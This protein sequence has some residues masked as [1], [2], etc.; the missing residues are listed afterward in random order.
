[1]KNLLVG[2]ALLAFA[3]FGDNLV[4]NGD[5]EA[6]GFTD[7]YKENCGSDYLIGWT[8]NKAG[9]ATPKGTYISTAIAA[10]DDS[11]WAFLKNVSSISQEITLPSAGRYRLEF[12]FCGRAG[13]Y[14]KNAN[15]VVS[16]DDQVLV[17]IV[18]DGKTE[19]GSKIEH[20]VCDFEVLASGA[21]V[22][23]F[24]QTKSGDLSPAFDNIVLCLGE[25]ANSIVVSGDP[26]NIGTVSPDFGLTMLTAGEPVACQL[27]SEAI[28]PETDDKRYSYAG[29]ELSVKDAAGE[30]TATSGPES[31]FVYNQAEGDFANLVW[32]WTT[33]YK[34]LATA[35]EGGTV[36]LAEAWVDEGRTCAITA[37]P[38]AG[39]SFT[40]WT[41]DV[42]AGFE[43][44]NPISFTVEKGAS[45]AA[46]FATPV[47][48]TVK[49]DGTGDFATLAEGV[50]A[51]NTLADGQVGELVLEPGGYP[52]TATLVLA[53]PVIVRSSTGDSSDVV[54]WADRT[55]GN[56]PVFKLAVADSVLRG[57]TISNGW[58]KTAGEGGGAT[59]VAG[60]VM[61]G[62]RVVGCS[63]DQVLGAV[64]GAYVDGGTVMATLFTG[65]M[66]AGGWNLNSGPGVYITKGGVVRGCTFTGNGAAKDYGF[67]CAQMYGGSL[68]SC[69]I[70]NNMSHFGGFY[71][72]GALVEAFAGDNFV[73]RCLIADNA[74]GGDS[75][76]AV[77][78]A[79]GN[80]TLTVE[81]STVAFNHGQKGGGF[82]R[83]NGTLTVK[84]SVVWGN[85]DVMLV[86]KRT[87]ATPEDSNFRGVPLANIVHCCSTIPASGSVVADPL[88]VDAPRGDYRLAANSPAAGMGCFD[89][90]GD[91]PA[92]EADAAD[93]VR[94]EPGDD[95][96][97]AIV[98]CREGG[99]VRVAAGD[100]PLF[101][102]GLFIAK[103]IS[104]LS[105]EGP[106]K[107]I[108][109]RAGV[110]TDEDR[111][112][113]VYIE[114]PD[115]VFGGFTLKN[116]LGSD[117][118]EVCA[119]AICARDGV[120]TNCTVRDC[121]IWSS[122]QKY[123]S[124]VHIDGTA[125]A[126]R[127][128]LRDN[129]GGGDRLGALVLSG[130]SPVVE[131]SIVSNQT[132]GTVW[133]S[134]AVRL[135]A[136][137]A[138]LRRSQVVKCSAGVSGPVGLVL[139]AGTTLENCVIAHNKNLWNTGGA[140]RADGACT[141]RN[142]TVVGNHSA[143]AAAGGLEANG[144]TVGVV[145]TVFFRNDSSKAAAND[146]DAGGDASAHYANCWFT[147]AAMV[148]AKRCEKCYAG[149]PQFVDGTAEGLNF[150]PQQ[151]SGL[152]DAGKDEVEFTDESGLDAYGLDRRYKVIDI[153]AVEY[154]HQ[155]TLSCTYA[156]EG[157]RIPGGSV[158]FTAAVDG[159]G[160]PSALLYR[161]QL[162]DGAWTEWSADAVYA[163]VLGEGSH[164]MVLAVKEGE[165]GTEV[166]TDMDGVT[167]VA[168]AATMHLV[169]PF[170]EGHVAREPY[171]TEETAATNLLDVVRLSGAGSDITIHP[172][173]HPVVDAASFS[174]AVR[175]H[176]ASGRPQDAVLYRP[177]EVSAQY[178]VL[179]LGAAGAWLDCVT[180]SNGQNTL[181]SNLNLVGSTASN[182]VIVASTGNAV[183]SNGG[184][185][186]DSLIRDCYADSYRVYHGENGSLI[187]RCTL[188]ANRQDYYGNG[189]AHLDGSRMNRCRIVNNDMRRGGSF[190]ENIV[191]ASGCGANL[192]GGA[193]LENTLISGNRS[194]C[195]G[196]VNFIGAGLVR[197]CTIV[198]NIVNAATNY[199]GNAKKWQVIGTGG[200]YINCQNQMA[201]VTNTICKLNRSRD[202]A[203]GFAD[204]SDDFA[205]NIG[206]A[207][208]GYSDIPAIGSAGVIR[209][210][211]CI[212][213]DP[214]FIRPAQGNF[215][216]RSSSSCLDAGLTWEGA[217]ETTDLRGGPRVK[218]PSVDMGCYECGDGLLLL[219]K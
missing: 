105:E 120:V 61:D 180:I 60:A 139:E 77:R 95:L 201:T 132:G 78:L 157:N 96:H 115:A 197:N 27:T 162:D 57:L 149:D 121:H 93:E 107:T 148:G 124:L 143:G 19:N 214:L 203:E 65:N 9:I 113:L 165:E 58:A 82:F 42:P 67:T 179:S 23:K 37:T 128:V 46:E 87:A 47:V 29:W 4:Q 218:G 70:T 24:E 92:V 219:V 63:S 150:T 151:G 54:V 83:S 15:T 190:A 146:Q 14:L 90:Q 59:L 5:F 28:V 166:T 181:G 104:V 194:H 8:C 122:N 193:I 152:K 154:H 184:R 53:K 177:K 106:E 43:K 171:A 215:R 130:A 170:V 188:T 138:V 98:K 118:L 49:A 127:L 13:S 216:L 202:R 123:S 198:S 168:A 91:E 11:A 159:A 153:G 84:D 217:R 102:H 158:T 30:T 183:Y 32:K 172:G 178:S 48:K 209:G 41:G 144:K 169:S 126:S 75:F 50:A 206:S 81:R 192:T 175:V 62:C 85:D 25:N 64:A 163:S 69:T 174:D 160:D 108:L 3:A 191:G 212:D 68:V 111:L 182:C 135:L 51:M 211:G 137:G 145:N 100:Y 109:R 97:A 55:G 141:I 99:T 161:W 26:K 186:V 20:V 21:H 164:R 1:M 36:S 40:K 112:R 210:E 18:G 89:Q 16:F 35:G 117:S 199:N 71:G 76:A 110:T 80:T 173:L 187:E 31:S 44:S 195:G 66:G 131:D 74:F 140:I 156:F 208:I 34:V 142:C 116:C 86:R 189:C 72:Y 136:G 133:A 6:K 2:V 134:P 200:I 125:R 101:R 33:Q 196:A 147:T 12:D 155:G 7:N 10:Y 207:K 88:F 39:Y 94:V 185:L 45:L 114:H 17:T 56:F 204:W 119:S 213:A 176:G 205:W 129:Y 22:L 38:S 79:T 52:V 73:T 167:I 103:G